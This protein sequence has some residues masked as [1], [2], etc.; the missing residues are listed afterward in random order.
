MLELLSDPQ[1]WIALATLTALRGETVADA[2]RAVTIAVSAPLAFGVRP[3]PIVVAAVHKGCSVAPPAGEP[4]MPSVIE[5][6]ADLNKPLYVVTEQDMYGCDP[7]F[8][9]PNAIKTREFLARHGLGV[10]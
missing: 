1:A 5:A 7:S 10:L 8:P 4:D 9:K 2:L 6:L 3:V